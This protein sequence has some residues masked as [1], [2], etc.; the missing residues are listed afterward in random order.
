MR[1]MWWCDVISSA[2]AE[3]GTYIHSET[4]VIRDS[5]DVIRD[6]LEMEGRVS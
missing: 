5:L 3:H 2:G 4:S 6:N 1:R